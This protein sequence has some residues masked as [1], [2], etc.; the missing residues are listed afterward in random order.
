M[1]KALVK[2][3]SGLFPNL[4]T[5][6]AYNQLTNPQVRKLRDNELKT[7]DKAEKESFLFK[8]FDIK[9]YT[10]KG[11]GKKIL[12]IH[13]WEGQAGNFSD[14]IESLIQVGYTVYAFDGPSHG[15]SSRGRTSLFE[16]TELVGVLIRKFEVRDLVS[17]SFG[18][19]ATTYALFNNKDLE[20]DKYVLLTT[21]DKFTERIDDVS[22]MVGISNNV[23]N[24]LIQRLEKETNIDVAS[25]NVSEF[26]KSINVKHSMIIHDKN[27]KVIPIS[28]SRNVHKNWSVSEFKEI[29]GTGH[30]RILR[31]NDV[32]AD[33]VDY[34]K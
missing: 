23:K 29:N 17:H 34:F 25:L 6:F 16:F 12:L 27:D 33:V 31:T 28:R 1:K 15:Y 18:G 13:G 7:L 21:P 26:V 8:G 10:W 11:E 20:I 24:K 32:I 9:L 2:I 3:V 30:F 4:L 14:L 5:A 22:E 19:V